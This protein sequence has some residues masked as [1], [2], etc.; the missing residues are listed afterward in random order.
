MLP[1]EVSW[2]GS[3]SDD[4]DAGEDEDADPRRAEAR[5]QPPQP[6]GQ[7]AV[8]AHRVDEP[9]HADDARVGGEEQDRRGEQADVQLG[10]AA[11]TAPRSICLTTPRI[12][13]PAKPPSS[14]VR[15]SSVWYSPSTR[16]TGSAD[17]ATAGSVK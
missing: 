17:S 12:G 8:D 1:E 11:G 13:S 16:V 14:S 4:R 7:L 2:P 10:R 15:P 5:V 6:V 3:S 9:R